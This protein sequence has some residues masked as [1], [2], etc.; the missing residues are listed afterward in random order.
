MGALGV[1][2]LSASVFREMVSDGAI[3][4]T[5]SAN[6]VSLSS[7]DGTITGLTVAPSIDVTWS[8]LDSTPQ[9]AVL[10]TTVTDPNDAQTTH[11]FAEQLV[12]IPSSSLS[13]SQ[14]L[15]MDK[16]R[17][18]GGTPFQASDF[19]SATDGATA[20]RAVRVEVGVQVDLADGSS[21]G[22]TAGPAEYLVQTTNTAATV[23]SG[24][25]AN[26]GGSA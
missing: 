26:T 9:S 7:D 15:S 23:S 19:E 11:T 21:I 8:G 16:Q 18:L 20:E 13:G 25:S 12:D 2:G 17:L 5:L 22:S 1:A 14:T 6:D 4:A 24:G 10:T 3:A